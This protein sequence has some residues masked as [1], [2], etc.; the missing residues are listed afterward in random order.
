[1]HRNPPNEPV[2]QRANAQLRCKSRLK[3]GSENSCGLRGGILRDRAEGTTRKDDCLRNAHN[4]IV[5][6]SLITQRAA[7]MC[8]LREI[9]ALRTNPH[10]HQPFFG[11]T[12][13]LDVAI[14]CVGAEGS[15]AACRRFTA[16]TDH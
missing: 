3:K 16:A 2:S 6:T 12:V 4:A 15:R 7:F 10:V 14:R 8:G 9:S 1:L 5:A 13:T 11:F